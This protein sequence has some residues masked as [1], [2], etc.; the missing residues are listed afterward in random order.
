MAENG[1][2]QP[3]GKSLLD[4]LFFSLVGS[5][6]IYALNRVIIS[7]TFIRVEP[8]TLYFMGILAMLVVVALLYNAYTRLASI[9][10]LVFATF[11]FFTTLEDFREQYTHLYELF[12]MTTGR[13]PF[14]AD[15]GATAAWFIVFLTSFSVTVLMFFLKSFYGLAITGVAVFLITWIPGF[16]RDET[17]FLFFLVA[18]ALILIRKTSRSVPTS[19]VAA[20]LC[21]AVILFVQAA[22]PPSYHEFYVRRQMGYRGDGPVTAIGDFLFELFNP[23]HFSFQSTGFSGAGGR[24][25]GPVTPNSRTVMTVNAPGRIYLSGATSNFYTGYSWISTLNPG[26]INTHGLQPGHFEMLETATALIRDA[27]HLDYARDF[28]VASLGLPFEESRQIERNH[29]SVLGVAD[30]ISPYLVYLHT[31][32]PLEVMTVAIGTNRTGTIFRPTRMNHIWFYHGST[33]YLPYA[34]VSPL[35]DLR[36]PFFM[37]RGTTYHMQFLNVRQHLSFLDGVLTNAGTGVYAARTPLYEPSYFVAALHANPTGAVNIHAGPT[38][39]YNILSPQPRGAGGLYT[40]LAAFYIHDR[41]V[42]ELPQYGFGV[43]EA[44]ALVNLFTTIPQNAIYIDSKYNLIGA[45]DYF[46]ANILA[47]YADEVRQHFTYVPAIVPQRV[48]DLTHDIIANAGAETQYEKAIAIRDFLLNEFPYTLNPVPVPRGVCFVD[49]FL[50]EGREG[51]CTYFAS[52]MAIMA[53]IAGIPSRYVEGFVLPPTPEPNTAVVVSNRMAHAW[54]EIYLEGFGWYI[55]EATPTYAFL[56]GQV[57]FLP[58]GLGGLGAYFDWWTI[59]DEWW[60]WYLLEGEFRYIGDFPFMPVEIGNGA[61]PGGDAPNVQVNALMA[62]GLFFASIALFV[63]LF[64][65]FRNFRINRR[66]KK[67]K[68][69]SPNEQAQVYFK[70]ILSLLEHCTEPIAQGVTP[71]AFG[72]TLG[73]RFSFRNDTMFLSDLVHIYYR[74]KYSSHEISERELE[75]M[76]SAYIE[77]VGR[78]RYEESR[79]RYFYLRLVKQ[80]GTV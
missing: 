73:K 29:F 3:T 31:Y 36:T 49:F 10:V 28:A 55:I 47:N 66:L 11:I 44:M 46:S 60:Y 79:P 64:V 72:L 32:L 65:L 53:R 80:L 17:A 12:L 51:Y 4:Y 58:V 21:I 14:R 34:E 26:D 45:L 75:F 16:T 23:V 59:Y 43:I 22:L 61:V 38:A 7:S 62:F 39:M 48:H 52:A 9:A 50:F 57:E 71:R 6:Y 2:K 13:L 20:P 19:L 33:N 78:L 41:D 67:V 37:S 54:V 74:A 56:M 15:L 8:F 5:I 40:G 25:G 18:F 42:T 70:G 68:D 69:L 76:E 1:Q 77:M 30:P 27:V 35:G 24:L 63:L